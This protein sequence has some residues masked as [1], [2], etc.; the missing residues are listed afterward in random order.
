MLFSFVPP[1]NSQLVLKDILSRHSACQGPTS[2]TS[3]LRN[4]RE[5]RTWSGWCALCG[6]PIPGRS[7]EQLFSILDCASVENALDFVILNLATHGP[8]FH[9]PLIMTIQCYTLLSIMCVYFFR[10]MYTLSFVQYIVPLVIIGF[11]YIRIAVVSESGNKG[12]VS[13]ILYLIPFLA[14]SLHCTFSGQYSSVLDTK[15]LLIIIWAEIKSEVRA[16]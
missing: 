6:G 14:C 5:I 10:Y 9:P 4:Y 12:C 3:T 8:P 15:P 13:S 1:S 11:A 2:L 7:Q 16:Q